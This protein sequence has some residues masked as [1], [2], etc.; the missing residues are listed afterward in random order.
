MIDVEVANTFKDL[1]I[2]L[3]PYWRL[4]YL[5]QDEVDVRLMDVIF[6]KSLLQLRYPLF[7]TLIHSPEV[8]K[9]S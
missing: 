4:H 5:V 6:H 9:V 2:T 1:S 3:L 8:K 7:Q